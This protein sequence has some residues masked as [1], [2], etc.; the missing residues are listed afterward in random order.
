MPD[1]SGNPTQAEISVAQAR[2]GQQQN[3]AAQHQHDL[4]E[5]IELGRKEFGSDAF[6]ADSEVVAG[7]LGV[8][9]AEFMWLAKQMDHPHRLVKHLADNP[10]RLEALA[11]MPLA[12]QA[13]ELARIESQSAPHGHVSTYA[14]PAWQAPEMRGRVSDSDW[15]ANGGANLSDKAWHKEYD[16][17]M[18]ERRKG[19]R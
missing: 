19:R 3:A 9:T 17:R 1:A 10:K 11:Q 5:I 2:L 7:K 12:R 18:A 13:V 8:K 14:Q 4:G 16:R 15:N 6:D